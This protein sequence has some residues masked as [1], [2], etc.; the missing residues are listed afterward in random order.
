MALLEST[1][2]RVVLKTLLLIDIEVQ[3]IQFSRNR[4]S[5]SFLVLLS[6]HQTYRFPKSIILSLDFSLLLLFFGQVVK[7][8]NSVQN[9]VD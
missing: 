8:I 9:K 7:M 3:L 2:D 5:V 1:K 4:D 6:S